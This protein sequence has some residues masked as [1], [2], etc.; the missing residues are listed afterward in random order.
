M[1]TVDSIII[2]INKIYILA[3]YLVASIQ[4]LLVKSYFPISVLAADCPLPIAFPR[5][6][7]HTPD[8]SAEYNSY[9]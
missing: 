5:Y 7:K 6:L 4:V 1:Y 8:G 2:M 3:T 9:F